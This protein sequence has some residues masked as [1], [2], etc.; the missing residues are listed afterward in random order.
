MEQNKMQKTGT[1]SKPR[2]LD[3]MGQRL[4]IDP[5]KLM[6]VLKKTVFKNVSDEEI[7]ALVVVSNE[8]NLNPFLKELYAF[9]AK[10]G[11][12]VPVVS[13]DGWNKMLIR[14]DTF[15]GI[16][17][18]TIDNEDGTV[19]SI[20][21]TIFVKNRSHPVKIT[22]YYSECYRETDNWKHMP[23]RMLRNRALCQGA[24]VAFGFAGIKDPDEAID[25][26]ATTVTTDMPATP[27]KAI[28]MESAKQNIETVETKISPQKKLEAC[29]VESGFSFDDFQDWAVHSG[30]VDTADSI[31]N[32]DEIPSE[33]CNRLLRAT[34][35]LLTGI[36][37]LKEA[38]EK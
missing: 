33:V 28:R 36:G 29:I 4:N 8:Y 23:R 34:N 13:V 24:R 18:E 32:F 25:V 15:D 26:M 27:L 5:S 31:S 11:G 22:E 16:E 38:T 17:F 3:I 7:A 12:I 37:K 2:A 6:D 14:Q 35:G 10:G 21:A 19:Y 30:Q 20:T 9:P 1:V